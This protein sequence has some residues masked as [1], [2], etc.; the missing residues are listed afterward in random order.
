MQQDIFLLISS[1]L[2]VIFQQH[3]SSWYRKLA[4]IEWKS[5]L[6]FIQAIKA[7]VQT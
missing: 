3:S 5:D 4:K 1:N 2:Q 7:M 6:H